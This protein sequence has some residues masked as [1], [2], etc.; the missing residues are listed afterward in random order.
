[1]LYRRGAST[2]VA[3]N[4]DLVR[5]FSKNWQ[6][7][8]KRLQSAAELVT[9]DSLKARG[10]VLPHEVVVNLFDAATSSPTR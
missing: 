1:L 3:K 10:Y 8:G 2:N 9:H 4:A 6:Q 5:K 7:A